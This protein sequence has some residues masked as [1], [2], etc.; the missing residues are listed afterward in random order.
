MIDSCDK[1]VRVFF[2][3]AKLY[4]YRFNN[5]F[6]FSFAIHNLSST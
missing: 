5:A 6:D 2:N 3:V 4:K 1:Y